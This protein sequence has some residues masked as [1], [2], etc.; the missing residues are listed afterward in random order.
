MNKSES[1][2]TVDT[3]P[4]QKSK[5]VVSNDFSRGIPFDEFAFDV[6][7]GLPELCDYKIDKDK[8]DEKVPF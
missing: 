7:T 4:D 3:P 8:K 2:I 1:V 6:I 5:A